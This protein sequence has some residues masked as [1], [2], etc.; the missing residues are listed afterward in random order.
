M[1][2]VGLKINA[3]RELQE[4]E[5][6]KVGSRISPTEAYVDNQG[7]IDPKVV[8]PDAQAPVHVP[9][10]PTRILGRG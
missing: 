3:E 8:N 9:R 7:M 6:R 2:M 1:A 5:K 10:K 4:N